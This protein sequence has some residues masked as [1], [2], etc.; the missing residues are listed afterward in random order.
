MN[1]GGGVCG[2]NRVVVI[3]G[4]NGGPIPQRRG[5]VGKRDT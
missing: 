1:V 5:G 4:L 2:F 3:D